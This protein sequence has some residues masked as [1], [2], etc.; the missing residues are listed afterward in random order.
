MFPKVVVPDGWVGG[1]G[2]VSQWLGD[3]CPKVGVPEQ[4][5]A[6]AMSPWLSGVGVPMDGFPMAGFP[7]AG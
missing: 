4:P 3:G 7:M 1:A 2:W 5:H 6:R